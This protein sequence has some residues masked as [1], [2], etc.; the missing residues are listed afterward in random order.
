M[1]AVCPK[2]KIQQKFRSNVQEKLVSPLVMHQ[3]TQKVNEQCSD[4]LPVESYSVNIENCQ[5]QDQVGWT[6]FTAVIFPRNKR[7]NRRY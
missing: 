3:E 7:V 5:N 1:F 6:T 2:F 4:P